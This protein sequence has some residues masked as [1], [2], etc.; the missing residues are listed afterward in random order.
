ML[1]KSI[2]CTYHQVK[3]SSPDRS[4]NNKSQ[5]KE[6]TFRKMEVY[7]KRSQE[8][9]SKAEMD[10][11]ERE[12]GLGR[13]TIERGYI[14]KWDQT[15]SPEIPDTGRHQ[16]FPASLR[17]VTVDR[18]ILVFVTPSQPRRSYQGDL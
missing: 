5:T 18:L 8:N 6:P 16:K 14:E 13:R 9:G 10:K 11:T 12:K 15:D 3:Y 7:G 17:G 4:K 2:W 1:H